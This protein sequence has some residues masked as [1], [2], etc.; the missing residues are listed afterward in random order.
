MIHVSYRSKE[1]LNIYKKT[2][3]LFLLRIHYIIVSIVLNFFKKFLNFSNTRVNFSF[4]N[5]FR[6]VSI[7][8]VKSKKHKWKDYQNKG[9]IC[10]KTFLW[11]IFEKCFVYLNRSR[12]TFTDMIVWRTKPDQKGEGRRQGTEDL[13]KT[14]G[15]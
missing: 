9:Y 14:T 15:K 7:H 6:T 1:L 13:R 10:L 2:K 5:N 8:I 3:Y 11:I 12:I 4:K